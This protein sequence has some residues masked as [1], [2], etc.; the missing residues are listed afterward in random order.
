MKRRSA[1]ILAAVGA[2]FGTGSAGYLIGR[3]R[4]AGVPASM[5]MTYSGV[6]EDTSGTPMTGAKEISVALWDSESGGSKRCSTVAA[7]HTLIGGRFQI[8][9]PD[10]CTAIVSGTPDLW[11]E[12]TVNNELLGRTKLGTVPFTLEAQRAVDAVG[13]IHPKTIS[14]EGSAGIGTT[15]TSARLTVAGDML[16]ADGSSA[17]FIEV[18]NGTNWTG[19]LAAANVGA[20]ALQYFDGT[21][22]H[23]GITL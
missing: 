3:A 9:L 7:S 22:W 2:A 15:P 5:P 20:L 14:S 19:R 13:D 10:D 18:R 4:A 16:V 6:L 21:S 11:V 17:N 23:A 8:P 12:V 1:V